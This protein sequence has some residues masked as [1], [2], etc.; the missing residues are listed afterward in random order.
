MTIS[1]ERD[2][3]HCHG[4]AKSYHVKT[5]TVSV[6]D[7]LSFSVRAGEC[8]AIVGP[9]GAGKSTLLNMIAGL[10]R[11]DSG[12]VTVWDTPISKLS[13]GSL[14][15]WRQRSVGV[16]FQSP[17]LH[18]ALRSEQNVAMP[19]HLQRLSRADRQARTR[20]ALELVGMNGRAKHLPREMSGGEC[21]RVALARALVCGSPL[22]VCDEPTAHLN[23]G[24]AQEMMD[25]LMLLN[26]EH[27]RTIVITT[28][29]PHVA[30]RADRVLYLSEGVLTQE[31][32][33]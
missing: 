31:A 23:A 16:L 13:E 7:H 2:A 33:S 19:L 20:A 3:I 1:P 18:Q 4:I 9:S 21:Q 6:L 5:G 15:A 14:A 27:R 8:V 30:A 26:T 22:L 25:V 24:A 32:A 29:D 11:P 17:F 12:E 10:D 28:H